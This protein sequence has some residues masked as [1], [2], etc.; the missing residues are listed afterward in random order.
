MDTADAL[1]SL[2]AEATKMVA[3]DLDNRKTI[4][5]VIDDLQATNIAS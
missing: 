2:I 5:A 4:N 1:A 3:D